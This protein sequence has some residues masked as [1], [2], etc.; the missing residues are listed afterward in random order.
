VRKSRWLLVLLAVAGI[1]TIGIVWVLREWTRL[2][3][4]EFFGYKGLNVEAI[5]AALPVHEGD[6]FP[7]PL[8]YLTGSSEQ[9]TQIIKDRVKQVTGREPTDVNFVCCDARQNFMVYIGLPGE[10]SQPVVF[11]PAP[12]GDVRLPPEVVKLREQFDDSWEE[13]VMNG[14]STEDDS[15]G[16]TL[17]NDPATRKKQLEIREYALGNE[18]LVLRV[19]AS[20]ADARHRSIAAQALG[21][22]R[23]SSEQIDALVHAS[24]DSDD[25]VRND[26]TRALGVLA[27]AKPDLARKIPAGPF[28]QLVKSGSWSG[29]NKGTLVLMALTNGRDPAILQ[30]L[31]SEALDALIEMARWRNAG[32]AAAAIMLLGRIARIEEHRLE[33]LAEKGQVDTVLAALDGR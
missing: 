31:R 25:G 8:T 14:R 15:A 1:S 10:S 20:S 29:H 5:R 28:I 2:G 23:Q 32:H 27:G 22:G 16:Y 11:N 24:L 3:E 6:L 7:P 9:L 4:I 12:S 18:A 13:A 33:E 30:Q 26:A 19:L 17:T 21:Y